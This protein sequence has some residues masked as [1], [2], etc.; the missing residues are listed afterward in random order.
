MSCNGAVVVV[1]QK[2]DLTR[3]AVKHIANITMLDIDDD[4]VLKDA[5]IYN[6]QNDALERAHIIKQ[7][8]IL[9]GFCFET[10][11][12]SF[13]TDNCIPDKQHTSKKFD[14]Q[15]LIQSFKKEMDWYKQE[16]KS[17]GIDS[18]QDSPI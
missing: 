2:N 16:L 9:S 3:F 8:L 12:I 1:N 17:M 6:S 10:E 5:E 14:G 4:E 13:Q 18:Y 7:D 11:V 15:I